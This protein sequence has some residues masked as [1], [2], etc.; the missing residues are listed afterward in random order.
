MPHRTIADWVQLLE[1]QPLPDGG[2]Y[3]ETYRARQQ[4]LPLHNGLPEQGARTAATAIYYLLTA[5]AFRAFHR[6]DSDLVWHFYFGAACQLHLLHP[7][8][9]RYES[10]LLGSEPEAYQHFHVLIPQGTWYAAEVVAPGEF[11]IVG[12]TT[13]PGFEW[14]D[15]HLATP[16]DLLPHFDSHRR[17]IERL[18]R[19][20]AD[21]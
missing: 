18:L 15:Y 10:V 1:L 17:L 16:A 9:R 20:A 11:S 12:C 5:G 8:T 4:V 21:A 13:A 3:R 19:P 6:L 14:G 7:A 2:Y